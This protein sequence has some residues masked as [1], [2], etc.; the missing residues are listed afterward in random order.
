MAFGAE[1]IEKALSRSLPI[2]VLRNNAK[3]ALM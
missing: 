1:D 2:I 3:K